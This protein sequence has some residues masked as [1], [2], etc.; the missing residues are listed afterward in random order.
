MNWKC[1]VN[2][3]YKIAKLFIASYLLIILTGCFYQDKNIK[4][5]V[6][7]VHYLNPDVHGRPEPLVI[8][9]Y[10][11][12]SPLR[13]QRANYQQLTQNTLQTLQTDLLDKRT[14][15][16]KPANEKF[17]KWNIANATQYLG[18]SAAYRNIHPMHWKKWFKL[19]KNTRRV[20][21]NLELLSQGIETKLIP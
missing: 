10:E 20:T 4:I 14:I 6:H 15:V 16:M 18:I 1:K 11:L 7:A 3:L 5:N 13:F 21:I 2:H 8:T 9:F 19:P 12:K 17:L